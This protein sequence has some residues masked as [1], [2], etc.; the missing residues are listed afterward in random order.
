MIPLDEWGLCE[1]RS[2]YSNFQCSRIIILIINYLKNFWH[3]LSF[4]YL[5]LNTTHILREDKFPLMPLLCRN[6]CPDGVKILTRPFTFSSTNTHII[7]AS[8]L[9]KFE[10]DSRYALHS[11][12]GPAVISH[13]LASCYGACFNV[14]LHPRKQTFWL[15]RR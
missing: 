2:V 8:H 7:Q 1:W 4:Y 9:Y 15:D 5:Q 13:P 12:D 6:W 3:N 10:G 14:R 11:A